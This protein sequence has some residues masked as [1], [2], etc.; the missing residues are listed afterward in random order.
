[1]DTLHFHLEIGAMSE[2][3][4]ALSDKYPHNITFE[5]DGVQEWTSGFMELKKSL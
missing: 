5:M 2:K 3:N 1:M 4:K